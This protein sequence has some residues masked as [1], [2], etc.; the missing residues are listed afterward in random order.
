MKVSK[1]SSEKAN[2][3]MNS[4]ITH[5]QKQK[6]VVYSAFICLSHTDHYNLRAFD[7]LANR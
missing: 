6:K 1:V 2:Y 3:K 4:M 7:L 5:F